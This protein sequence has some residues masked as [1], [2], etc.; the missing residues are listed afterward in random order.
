[1]GLDWG[2]DAILKEFASHEVRCR[3]RWSMTV[4]LTPV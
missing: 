3:F 2:D 1:M 4:V